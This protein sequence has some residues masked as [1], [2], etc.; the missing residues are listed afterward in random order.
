MRMGEWWLQR[1]FEVKISTERQVRNKQ[2]QPFYVFATCCICILHMSGA[3]TVFPPISSRPR[4]PI[5]STGSYSSTEYYLPRLYS[6]K[7]LSNTLCGVCMAR[8]AHIVS[9]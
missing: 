4:L 2:E 1:P 9:T 3:T 8:V 7:C 5:G 6:F